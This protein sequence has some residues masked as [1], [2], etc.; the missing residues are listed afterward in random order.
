M[1]ANVR[2]YTTSWC[3]Y[4]HRAK[5]L[6]SRKNVRFEEIDVDGRPELRRWLADASGQSTVPQIFINNR[7]HGGFTDI[8]RLDAQGKLDALLAETPTGQ[9]EPLPS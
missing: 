9:L 2:I 1:S 4:C 7:P 8:S 6:L 5:S 3:P